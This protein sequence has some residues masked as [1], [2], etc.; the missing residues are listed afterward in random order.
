[1]ND[2][3][4]LI[5][6]LNSINDS[7]I[8]QATFI[9]NYRNIIALIHATQA[10]LLPELHVRNLSNDTTQLNTSL[11]TVTSN[12]L[13]TIERIIFHELQA[14]TSNAAEIRE[15]CNQFINTLPTIKKLLLTDIKA[16]YEGD[17]ACTSKVEVTLAYPGFYAMLIHRTAHALYELNVPLIPRLMSEYAHRKT[18]IDIHPGAKIGAYFCID[19]GTGIVIGE[20]TVI[21]EHVKLYQGVTLGAKSFALD[22]D[23]NPVKGGKRH[24]NIG[25][26]VVIYA[27]ATILGGETTIGS[28]SIIAANA[29]I[30]RSIPAN[31]TYHFPKA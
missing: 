13:D 24:P 14:Y 8:R 27:N 23:G 31:T 9:P 10:L 29:W 6:K 15:T 17:P 26:N 28:G 16:M 21:G 4:D 2:H 19:H 12:A 3:L 30:N 5:S 25:N 7:D 11:N 18:G 22:E 20:T 1:M